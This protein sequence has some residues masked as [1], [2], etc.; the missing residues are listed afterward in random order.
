[1]NEKD[2]ATL[3]DRAAECV[4]VG[5]PPV[6][7]TVTAGQR[8]WKHRVAARFVAAVAAGAAMVGAGVGVHSW[9]DGDQ[10]VAAVDGTSTCQQIEDAAYP[11]ME[12][13]AK[14]TLGG[15]NYSLQRVGACADTGAPRAVLYAEV[16]NWRNRSDAVAFFVDQGWTPSAGMLVSPDGLYRVNNSTTTLPNSRTVVTAQFFRIAD[17][18]GATG[19]P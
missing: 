4:A 12:T 18:T 15:L 9:T 7:E 17:G 16:R 8:R 14:D 2:T 5:P 1:M 3:L 19:S 10:P 6:D 11:A 13:L